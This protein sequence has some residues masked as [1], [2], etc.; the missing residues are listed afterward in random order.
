M[1]FACDFELLG[2]V[3]SHDL[4]EGGVTKQVTEQNKNEYIE[5]VF[6]WGCGQWVWL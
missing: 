2:V 5:L 6:L 4:T 3:K 1:F